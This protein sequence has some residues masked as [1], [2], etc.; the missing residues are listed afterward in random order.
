MV[1]SKQ[2]KEGLVNSDS[3]FPVSAID[4]FVIIFF[5]DFFSHFIKNALKISIWRNI[6]PLS[7]V[8]LNQLHMNQ[9]SIL[10]FST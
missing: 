4:L 3:S 9:E 2:I 1:V 5:F 10:R 7:V 6:S 8:S